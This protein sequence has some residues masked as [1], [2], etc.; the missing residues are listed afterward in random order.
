MAHRPVKWTERK[1]AEMESKGNGKG[2]LAT[3]QPWL[4]VEATNSLGRARR[5]WSPKTGRVHH[6]LSD[7]EYALFL[8][9]EWQQDVVDIREQ[10]PLDRAMSQE[11]ARSIG[12]RHPFYPGTQVPTVMTADFLVTKQVGTEEVLEAFNA[13]RT[14]EAADEASL[15]KLE[16]QREYFAQLGIAHHLVFHTNIP[17]AVVANIDWIRNAVVKPN[18]QEPRPGYFADLASSMAFELAHLGAGTQPLNAYCSDFDGNHGLEPGTGLRVA[19]VLMLNRVLGADL[20]A[21]NLV[22]NPLSSFIVTAQRGKLR[23][24]GG[25]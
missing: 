24:V 13:K 6:L 21:S 11:V 8:A 9:L 18:E 7:V 12:A 10:Y 16:I 2:R 3:Y 17:A 23:S 4:T 25:L 15:S 5:V 14:E 22:E 20:H 19:R 1:I